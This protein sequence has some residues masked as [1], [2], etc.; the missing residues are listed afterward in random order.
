MHK[1]NYFKIGMIRRRPH[2]D[3]TCFKSCVVFL[4]CHPCQK[5]TS[6]QNLKMCIRV[7]QSIMQDFDIVNIRRND[8]IL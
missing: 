7:L 8:I 1:C 6:S 4:S 5:E 3:N 2:Y